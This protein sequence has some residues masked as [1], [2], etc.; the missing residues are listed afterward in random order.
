M[1]SNLDIFLMSLSVPI[2]G[3]VVT[4][5]ALIIFN[6][7]WIMKKLTNFN[8]VEKSIK[9]QLFHN[10]NNYPKSLAFPPLCTFS[11]KRPKASNQ[12]AFLLPL[13]Q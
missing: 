11:Q 1:S 9:I 3:T 7:K 5:I 6:R 8:R 2:G 12:I 4:A 10:F 13:M